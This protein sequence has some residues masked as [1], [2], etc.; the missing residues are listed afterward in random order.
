MLAESFHLTHGPNF[1]ENACH[2]CHEWPGLAV[3]QL[4]DDKS[5]IG[6]LLRDGESSHA[7]NLSNRKRVSCVNPKCE[8][9]KQ[10]L[11]KLLSSIDWLKECLQILKTAFLERF[12]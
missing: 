5:S 4:R 11:G 8:C 10:K 2:F 6:L 1:T 3:V 12:T 7:W 9:D